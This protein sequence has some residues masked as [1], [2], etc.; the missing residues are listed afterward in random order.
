MSPQL[1]PGFV[2]LATHHCVT[3]SLRHVYECNG[4]PIS[5]EL[6]LGLGAGIGFAYFQFKGQ[7][8]FLGGRANV[9][10]PGEE[11]LERAA[12]RR[13]GVKVELWRTASAK[14]A[15]AALL[16]LLESG[17]PVMLGVD[18]GYLPYFD[19][20]EEFHFGGHAI[21]VCGY[22]AQERQVLV[23]DRDGVPHPVS[24]AQLA[25]ARGSKHKPFPPE[26]LWYTF[27]FRE[28]Q[29]PEPGEVRAAIREVLAGL[30]RPPIANLG[31]K[32]I[33]KAAASLREWP[34][35]MGE[36]EL[37]RACFN[38]FIFIDYTGGTGGGAFRYLYGRFLG[39]AAAITGE[40]RLVAV[41]EEVRAVGDRWQEAA[42]LLKETAAA[43]DPRGLLPETSAIL[44][45]IADRELVV[46][47][48]LAEMV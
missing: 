25:K 8:P 19:F 13:T 1:L 40:G 7:P 9:G 46:W 11:G 34:L 24:L 38:A 45:D 36:A 18:M 28:R 26:H 12:G 15:E 17:Q 41:G 22:D 27:D 44:Q 39:E 29:A 35:A 37:R 3:G 31:V 48:R 42:L 2:P 10:R 6:L 16:G 43:P 5:E 21:V 30:L 32:G 20:P 23:A 4:Y 14:K 33:R 47:D